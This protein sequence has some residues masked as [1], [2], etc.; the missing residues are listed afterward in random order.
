V[1]SRELSTKLTSLARLRSSIVYRYQ[2]DDAGIYRE[3]RD[4]GIE[5]VS[6]AIEELRRAVDD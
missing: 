3:A 5:A 1:L 2:L 4:R 6:R